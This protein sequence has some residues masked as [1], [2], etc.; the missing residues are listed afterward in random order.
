MTVADTT[1]THRPIYRLATRTNGW[2]DLGVTVG[3][4]GLSG[5]IALLRFD[6]THYPANPTLEPLVPATARRDVLIAS[7]QLPAPATTP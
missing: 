7:P 4:G 3:G 1:V 2:A 5:S 6:G